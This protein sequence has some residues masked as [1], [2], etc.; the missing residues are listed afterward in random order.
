MFY[1]Q[2]LFIHFF[3][4]YITNSLTSKLQKIKHGK[5]RLYLQSEQKIIENNG[6]LII[7]NNSGNDERFSTNTEPFFDAI[8]FKKK[9]LLDYLSNSIYSNNEK[10]IKMEEYYYKYGIS[11]N[12]NTIKAGNI[13]FGGLFKDWNIDI[14]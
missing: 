7:V 13:T 9:D 14:L 2:K 8:L 12:T 5:C 4:F 1:I 10:I 11:C 6:T 3:Q